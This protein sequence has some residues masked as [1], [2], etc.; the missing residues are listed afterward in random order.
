MSFP[1]SEGCYILFQVPLCYINDAV[2]K[3]ANDWLATKPLNALA[4]FFLWGLNDVMHDIMQPHQHGHKG[5]K[6]AP[7]PSSSKTKAIAVLF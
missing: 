5:S 3:T 7:M 4:D 6:G 1:F 2:I